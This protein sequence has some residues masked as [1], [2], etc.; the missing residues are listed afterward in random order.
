MEETRGNPVIPEGRLRMSMEADNRLLGQHGDVDGNLAISRESL[1]GKSYEVAAN[2]PVAG[3]RKSRASEF[4]VHGAGSAY[5]DGLL[6]TMNVLP[7]WTVLDVGGAGGALSIPLSRKVKN[8]KVIHFRRDAF[9]LSRYR[10]REGGVGN[11]SSLLVRPEYI[12]NGHDVGKY[13]AVVVSG[14]SLTEDSPYGIMTLDNAAKSRVF[15]CACVGDGPFDRRVFEAAGRK[16]DMGPS[17]TRVYYNIIHN[18]LGILPDISFIEEKR[19]REWDNLGEAMDA[20]RWMFDGLTG[21]EEDGIRLFLEKNL[22]EVN[23]RL[24]LPYERECKWAVMSWAKN[25][26]RARDRSREKKSRKAMAAL[27]PK[28][29]IAFE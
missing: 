3:E 11:L 4:S 17:Y 1:A 16:L 28:A 24:R 26:W 12:R 19:P 23:G 22:I 6:T 14:S 21:E 8:V 27:R 15:V 13:D 9:D 18:Y 5:V 7:E 2:L 20:Q 25:E 29:K 10:C